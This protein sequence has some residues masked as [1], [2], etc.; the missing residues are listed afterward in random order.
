MTLQNTFKKVEILYGISTFF[1]IFVENNN[2]E[3]RN[4]KRDIR[5][6]SRKIE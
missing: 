3:T 6:T 5:Y 1:F 2:Y 4:I